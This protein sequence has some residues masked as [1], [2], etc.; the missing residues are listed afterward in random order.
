MQKL[1]TSLLKSITP[2]AKMSDKLLQLKFNSKS[3]SERDV[4]EFL[5]LSLDSLAFIGHS[6]NEVNIKRRELI[7]PDLNV[8][9]KQLCGSI[10]YSQL[11]RL[12]RL[13]SEDS[14][15]S[16]RS[17]ETCHF[18][19]KRGYPAS[20]V[21][22]GH[23]RAKQIDRSQHYKRLRRRIIIEFHSPSHFTLTTTQLNPP[24]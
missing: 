22:A 14:D 12:R 19:D 11:L 5:Q 10:P 3:A 2:I 24:L 20:V 6:I 23:H 7:K 9:F 4:S 21:Q 1:E 16:L 15:F 13:C 18:F 8:Q 17:E